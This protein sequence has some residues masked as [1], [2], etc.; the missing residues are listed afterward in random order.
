MIQNKKQGLIFALLTVMITVPCFV[1]YCLSIESKGILNVDV[2]FA[3]KIIPIEFVLAYLSE[4]FIASPLSLKVAMKAI[5]P[6]KNSPMI[7]ESAIICSTVVIMCTWMSFLATILYKGIFPALV[8]HDNSWSVQS[9]LVTFIP[10]YLQTVVFNFPFAFF[11]Q[12]FF[13]QPLVRRVFKVIFRKKELPI[14]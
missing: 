11:S 12:M 2:G 10:N 6:K 8:F 4:I 3:L 5:D 14:K 7:V 9:F 1:V 13:I